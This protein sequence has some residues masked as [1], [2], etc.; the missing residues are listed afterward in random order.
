M[1][2]CNR[3][4]HFLPC[5]WRLP[6]AYVR[7]VCSQNHREREKKAAKTLDLFKDPLFRFREKSIFSTYVVTPRIVL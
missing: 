4:K 3:K 1:K 6:P 7:C 2:Y 5:F